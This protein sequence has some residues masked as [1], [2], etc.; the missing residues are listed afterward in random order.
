MVFVKKEAEKKNTNKYN[1]ICA[2]P[3]L[4]KKNKCRDYLDI[5]VNVLENKCKMF[6]ERD[7]EAVQLKPDET[8]NIHFSNIYTFITN[9]TNYNINQNGENGEFQQQSQT[10]SDIIYLF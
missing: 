8:V 1:W 2:N 3:L 10:I 7:Y 6:K 4:F 5:F 9:K